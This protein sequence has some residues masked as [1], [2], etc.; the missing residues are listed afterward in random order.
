MEKAVLF[1]L[2]SSL[3]SPITPHFPVSFD[4]GLRLMSSE[5]PS[6][7]APLTLLSHPSFPLPPKH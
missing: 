3:S 7:L 4:R 5:K 1:Y 2:G 6:F